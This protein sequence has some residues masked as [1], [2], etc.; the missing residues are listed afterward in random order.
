MNTAGCD[1][2]FKPGYQLESIEE[3]SSFMW[4]YRY[5]RGIGPTEDVDTEINVFQMTTGLLN[6]LEK[7]HIY[8]GRLNTSLRNRETENADLRVRLRRVESALGITNSNGDD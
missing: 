2:V 7:A 4:T 3:H 8:I 5:L 1:A 6:E